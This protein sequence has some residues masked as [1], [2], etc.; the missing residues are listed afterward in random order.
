MPPACGAPESHRSGGRGVPLSGLS[1]GPELWQI[2][3]GTTFPFRVRQS[4]SR[5]RQQAW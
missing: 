5:I 1:P 4:D 2:W 3:R